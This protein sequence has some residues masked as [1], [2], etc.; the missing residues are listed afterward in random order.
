MDGAG[1][2]P[3]DRILLIGATNRPQE[4]DEAM[5]RRLSKRM[6]IPLPN[7]QGRRQILEN[8]MKC[9]PNQLS[10][11]E[12]DQ[13]VEKS[14][15][16]SGSDMKNLC[17]EASM[18]PLRNIVDFSDLKVDEVPPVMIHHFLDAF[19]NTRS[20]VSQQDIKQLLEW[21]Q[22]FGSFQFDFSELDT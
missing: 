3:D 4:L 13:V 14:K 17:T 21:N 7:A 1:T 10:N 18:C 9:V 15:G 20:S 16:Y 8:L 5:R 11:E 12:L 22:N 2:N 6:Y 19:K